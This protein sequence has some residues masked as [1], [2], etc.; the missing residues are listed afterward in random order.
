MS[1]F[2][3]HLDDNKMNFNIENLMYVPDEVN[4]WSRKPQGAT[5]S[6]SKYWQSVKF[7][8]VVTRT[9]CVDSVAEALHAYDT[10][11]MFAC[12]V[13]ARDFIFTHGLVRPKEFASY[14]TTPDNLATRYRA[15]YTP[16]T[17]AGRKKRKRTA[18]VRTI[19]KK[20]TSKSL[21]KR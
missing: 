2:V 20:T 1:W 8:G 9:K 11:K 10:A 7:D 16:A 14:Y 15:V 19:E 21:R 18:V 5:R 4:R 12:P 17:I 6:A 3:A 13:R